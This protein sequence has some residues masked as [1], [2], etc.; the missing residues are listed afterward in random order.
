MDFSRRAA[1]LAA[2]L[3]AAGCAET[4]EGR[5]VQAE[6]IGAAAGALIGATLAEEGAREEAI[7]AGALLGA[8]A[9]AAAR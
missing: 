5:R 3:S 1:A 6:L 7:L 8:E 2:A 9:V 4:E